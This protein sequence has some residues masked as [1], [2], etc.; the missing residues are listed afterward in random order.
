[1]TRYVLLKQDKEEIKPEIDESENNTLDPERQE[2]LVGDS[3]D[4]EEARDQWIDSIEIIL[5]NESFERGQKHL[6]KNFDEVRISGDYGL[7]K[8]PRWMI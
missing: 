6:R 5:E 8:T 4:T 2:M 7:K 1:L 3:F